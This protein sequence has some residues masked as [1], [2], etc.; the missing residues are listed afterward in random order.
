M[1]HRCISYNY[2]YDDEHVMNNFI[3]S[4]S[5]YEFLRI[6]MP[7]TYLTLNLSQ[8]IKYTFPDYDTI[9]RGINFNQIEATIIFAIVSVVLGVFIYSLDNPRLL[10]YLFKNLPSNIIR[11]RHRDADNIAILNSYFAFYDT[12]PDA[13]RIKTEKQ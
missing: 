13:V 10:S 8:F 3:S 4:F 5:L 2:D 7:G 11:K 9:S 1:V 6:L 12:L